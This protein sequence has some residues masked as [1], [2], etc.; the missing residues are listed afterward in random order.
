MN[1]LRIASTE[2]LSRKSNSHGRRI[3]FLDIENYVGK[4]ILD[5]DDVVSA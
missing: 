2:T 1:A 5:D 3:F 4:A